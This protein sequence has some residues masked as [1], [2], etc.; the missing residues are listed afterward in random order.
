[1][2]CITTTDGIG[3]CKIQS[4]KCDDYY[5]KLSSFVIRFDEV[6][7]T[8]PPKTLLKTVSR[9][10]EDDCILNVVYD[11]SSSEKTVFIG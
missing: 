2:N 8:L 1:M 4:K 10:I 6:D 7:Y 5:S 9:D 11:E 3:T